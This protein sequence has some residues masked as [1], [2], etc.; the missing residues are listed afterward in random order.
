MQNGEVDKKLTNKFQPSYKLEVT[1][2]ENVEST[3]YLG[4]TITNDFEW[5]MHINDVCTKANRTL[6]SLRR[7]LICL[8]P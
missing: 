1:V 3:K 5:N 7:A 6:G 8:L 2:L 4:G